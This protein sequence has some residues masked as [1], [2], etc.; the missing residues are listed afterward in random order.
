MVVPV[1]DKEGGTRGGGIN[2]FDN[3]VLSFDEVS[4]CVK[5]WF[6]CEA[7]GQNGVGRKEEGK[8]ERKSKSTGNSR[9]AIWESSTFPACYG[10]HAGEM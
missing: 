9:R 3:V 5:L 4:D 7:P 10:V 2:V 1:K 6:S 8:R